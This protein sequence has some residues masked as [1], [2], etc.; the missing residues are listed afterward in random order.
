MNCK[1]TR[2]EDQVSDKL[3]D[4]YKL[5]KLSPNELDERALKAL[6]ELPVDSALAVLSKFFESDLDHV[7]NK[8]AY[9]CGLMKSFR[10]GLHFYLMFSVCRSDDGVVI[11]Y[12]CA[13]AE[14]SSN[15]LIYKK[16]RRRFEWTRI[17]LCSRRFCLISFFFTFL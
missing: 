2:F 12:M 3:N 1:D 16:S 9:L 8:S 11:G 10:C 4:L 6:E 5:D 13:M 14:I 17:K 7:S 15:S